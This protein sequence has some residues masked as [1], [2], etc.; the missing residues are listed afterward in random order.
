MDFN[1]N[2][3]KKLYGSLSDCE[4]FSLRMIYLIEFNPPWYFS[5]GGLIE[6]YQIEFNQPT[7]RKIPWWILYQMNQIKMNVSVNQQIYVMKI[8]KIK[9]GLSEKNQPIILFRE[10]G[11]KFQLTIGKIIL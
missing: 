2:P 4:T 5:P 1:W 6:F 8:S 11:R 9:R 3:P 10:I 7:R